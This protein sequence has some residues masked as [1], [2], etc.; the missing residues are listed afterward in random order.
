MGISLR[1]DGDYQEVSPMQ[2][3]EGELNDLPYVRGPFELRKGW[4]V[5][6]VSGLVTDEND[7]PICFVPPIL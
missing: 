2:S 3:T 5:G 4:S 6:L 1:K 7:R